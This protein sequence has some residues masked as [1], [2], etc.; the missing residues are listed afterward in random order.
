M[1]HL[2]AGP[3]KNDGRDAEGQLRVPLSVFYEVKIH[4]RGIVFVS[5]GPRDGVGR[6]QLGWVVDQGFD[7]C[8]GI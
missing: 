7:Y 8:L 2:A 3:D 4:V 1:D 6:G 5:D